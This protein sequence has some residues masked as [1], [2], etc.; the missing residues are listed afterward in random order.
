[1]IIRELNRMKSEE[2]VEDSKTK[3]AEGS[4]RKRK[5]GEKKKEKD[6]DNYNIKDLFLPGQKYVTPNDVLFKL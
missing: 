6:D 2:G 1:M 3:N 4:A 5:K